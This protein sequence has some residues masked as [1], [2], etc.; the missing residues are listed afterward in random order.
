MDRAV[1]PNFSAPPETQMKKRA[2]HAPASDKQPEG[3]IYENVRFSTVVFPPRHRPNKFGSA[4]GLMKTFVCFQQSFS[5]L[6]I[7]RASAALLIWLNENVHFHAPFLASAIRVNSIV[8]GL[9]KT[10]ISCGFYSIGF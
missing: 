4:L 7:A 6:G 10:F 8:L 5:R 3:H 2:P 1:E 9:T